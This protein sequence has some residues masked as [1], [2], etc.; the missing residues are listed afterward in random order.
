MR[1]E[2]SFGQR[3]GYGSIE[4]VEVATRWERS[5]PPSSLNQHF[6]DSLAF[7]YEDLATAQNEAGRSESLIGMQLLNAPL[8]RGAYLPSVQTATNRL[9]ISGVRKP[10]G[11]LGLRARPAS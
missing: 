4:P 9:Q 3:Y 10:T 11:K 5:L 6:Q 2:H 7:A 1:R 8:V